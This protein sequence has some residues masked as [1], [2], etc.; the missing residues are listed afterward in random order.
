MNDNPRLGF[1]D[2]DAEKFSAMLDEMTREKVVIPMDEVWNED[3]DESMDG[4]WDSAMASAGFGTDEDY[5]IFDDYNDFYGE[6]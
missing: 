3:Y 1:F 2:V 4:D 5:G 6:E